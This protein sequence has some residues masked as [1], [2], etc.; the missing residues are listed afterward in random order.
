MRRTWLDRI[1]DYYRLRRA[2][3]GLRP[4]SSIQFKDVRAVLDMYRRVHACAGD[5]SG[6][7]VNALDFPDKYG[8]ECEK[9][10]KLTLFYLTERSAVTPFQVVNA[11]ARD[12]FYAHA[13]AAALNRG[14]FETTVNLVYLLGPDSSQRFK[15]F[16]NDS[17]QREFKL[18]LGMER[19]MRSEDASLRQRA[20]KQAGVRNATTE[21]TLKATRELVGNP[22]PYPNLKERCRRLGEW[23]DFNY[24]A[25][26]RGLSSW[27][28]G[29]ASRIIASQAFGQLYPEQA[30]R[31]VFE[32]LAHCAWAWDLVYNLV[33]ELTKYSKQSE[34]DRKEL[35]L[36]NQCGHAALGYH[37]GKAVK[38]FQG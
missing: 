20:E 7:I 23:W 3:R 28:H 14:L 6:S 25:K 17:V 9:L 30:E 26:Y 11:V 27:Q 37:L 33:W 34:T 22:P 31:P 21:E 18:Q 16:Y 32:S 19:W 36:L 8:P 2:L 35:Q 29:D 1:A 5:I 12:P 38:K 13:D 4:D 15:S 10:A 24:D